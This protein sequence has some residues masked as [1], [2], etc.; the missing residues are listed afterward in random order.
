M[1]VQWNDLIVAFTNAVRLGRNQITIISFGQ[2]WQMMSF[3]VS[4]FEREEI[5]KDPL[6]FVL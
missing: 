4:N 2:Q 6:T 5:A 1:T 3:F